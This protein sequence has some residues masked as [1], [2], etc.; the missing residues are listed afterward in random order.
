MGLNGARM[1]T[2]FFVMVPQAVVGL[3]PN[4]LASR[5]RWSDTWDTELFPVESCFDHLNCG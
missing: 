5:S 4:A 1:N 3:S 2:Q